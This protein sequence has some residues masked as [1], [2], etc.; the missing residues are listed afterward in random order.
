MTTHSNADPTLEELLTRA[1]ALEKDL[2]VYFDSLLP[3]LSP[4]VAKRIEPIRACC[5]RNIEELQR[6]LDDTTEIQSLTDSIAD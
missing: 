2:E 4:D 3:E 5:A 1:L 6:I